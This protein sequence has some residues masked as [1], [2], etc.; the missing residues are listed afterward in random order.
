MCSCRQTL[1]SP[2]PDPPAA[3]AQERTHYLLFQDELNDCLQS[4]KGQK[5]HQLYMVLLRDITIK[6]TKTDQLNISTGTLGTFVFLWNNNK[7]NIVILYLGA[8][9]DIQHQH[10]LSNVTIFGV[11]LANEWQQPHCAPCCCIPPQSSRVPTES[12]C[13]DGRSSSSRT[14]SMAPRICR[15]LFFCREATSSRTAAVV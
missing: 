3:P 13:L 14:P 8:A 11:T 12:V 6:Y 7:T 9:Q 10:Q 5:Q 4:N 1:S 2:L 15:F